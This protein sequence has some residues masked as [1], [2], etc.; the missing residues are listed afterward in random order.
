M[1]C[2]RGWPVGAGAR[3][4]R[5][6]RRGGGGA[7]APPMRAGKGANVKPNRSSKTW[8]LAALALLV[9]AFNA[10]L[11]FGGPAEGLVLFPERLWGNGIC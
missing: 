2:R 6:L 4:S 5:E 10:P 7:A 1:R 11:L 9:A 3:R 8:E